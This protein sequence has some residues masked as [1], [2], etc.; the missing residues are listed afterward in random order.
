M[1]NI[2]DGPLSG[3]GEEERA[4][5]QLSL[6]IL[7]LPVQEMARAVA[8]YRDMLGFLPAEGVAVELP[9]RAPGGDGVEHP[10]GRQ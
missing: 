5:A 10:I 3:T 1:C 2:M 8:F 9:Y 7:K 6:N 4:M